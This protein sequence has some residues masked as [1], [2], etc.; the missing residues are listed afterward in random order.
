MLCP[1]TNR[2]PLM[3]CINSDM[4]ALWKLLPFSLT[5]PTSR[6]LWLL[7]SISVSINAT[8]YPL[9]PTSPTNIYTSVLFLRLF[10]LATSSC[11]RGKSA[12]FFDSIPAQKFGLM[13]KV[14]H[15]PFRFQV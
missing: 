5:L 10:V 7:G 1:H 4:E 8:E 9:C 6:I 14:G 2:E 3:N 13:S 15:F 11:F 12:R